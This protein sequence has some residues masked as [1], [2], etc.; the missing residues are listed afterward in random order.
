MYVCRAIFGSSTAPEFMYPFL[1]FEF[2]DVL[3]DLDV[4]LYYNSESYVA[5][6]SA[7]V[8]KIYQISDQM[9]SLAF[10]F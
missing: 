5:S 6:T 10:S 9:M 2:S 8:D 3:V 4:V 1:G 7:L